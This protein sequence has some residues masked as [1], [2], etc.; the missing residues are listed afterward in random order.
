MKSGHAM[1]MVPSDL[2]RDLGP[3]LEL[4]QWFQGTRTRRQPNYQ[5]RLTSHLSRSLLRSYRWCNRRNRIFP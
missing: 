5:C 4:L 1:Y 3:G 2:V